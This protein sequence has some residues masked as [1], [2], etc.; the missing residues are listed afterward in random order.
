MGTRGCGGALAHTTSTPPACSTRPG[1]AFA[2]SLSHTLSFTLT[3][4]ATL[5]FHQ[6]LALC[7]TGMQHVAS[8]TGTG[9][10]WRLDTVLAAR[11]Q[12]LLGCAP[13]LCP[14]LPAP[15][16]RDVVLP[17]A[18]CYLHHTHPPLQ[19]AA[20]DACVAALAALPAADRPP[21]APG[22]VARAL[23]AFPT[24]LDAA[25]LRPLIEA[26]LKTMPSASVQSMQCIELVLQRGRVL[27][28]HL[29]GDAHSPAT[30]NV[31][32]CT[33]TATMSDSRVVGGV[34]SQL[35][36]L[37]AV[38]LLVVDYQVFEAALALVGAGV[39]GLGGGVVGA[40]QGVLVA[41]DDYTRKLRLASW[42]NALRMEMDGGRLLT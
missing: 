12:F 1:C 14:A 32:G 19:A 21:T 4:T 20:L 2:F 37:L 16:L 24:L 42:Y 39:K 9:A 15:A 30:A 7:T 35:G 13:A 25:A 38:C 11:M 29:G 27:E 6:L 40:M 33:Q 34:C 26:A 23:E 22:V 41:G 3:P 18:A 28:P 10:M 17:S 5:T 36:L 8:T 31:S